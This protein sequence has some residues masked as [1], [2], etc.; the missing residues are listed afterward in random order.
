M[1][2]YKTSWHMA[3]HRKCAK[4]FAFP[5]KWRIIDKTN[6]HYCIHIC[7]GVWWGASGWC[8]PKKSNWKKKLKKKKEKINK[9]KIIDQ[10]TTMSFTNGSKVIRFRGGY[11]LTPKCFE[12]HTS[13]K[14]IPDAEVIDIYQ[15]PLMWCF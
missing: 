12:V 3:I 2:T 13:P 15:W 11:P 10:I 4:D 9:M 1:K 7:R 6:T 8:P 5:S 14:F